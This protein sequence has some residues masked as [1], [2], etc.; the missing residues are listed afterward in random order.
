MTPTLI[1]CNFDGVCIRV[2]GLVCWE[3]GDGGGGDGGDGGGDANETR[4]GTTWS[5]DQALF[6]WRA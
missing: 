1:R 4:D 5:P 2:R 3:S 6:G